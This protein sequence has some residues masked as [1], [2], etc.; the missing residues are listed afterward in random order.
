MI[1][2]GDWCQRGSHF[3]L[4]AFRAGFAFAALDASA[5][6]RINDSTDTRLTYHSTI[7]APPRNSPAALCPP[8]ARG[9][10]RF[11]FAGTAVALFS[12][13]PI[14]PSPKK[15]DMDYH[16]FV[17]A[18]TPTIF[19]AARVA[20]PNL[21]PD[22]GRVLCWEWRH[23]RG[24]SLGDGF[25]TAMLEMAIRDRVAIDG[26]HIYVVRPKNGRAGL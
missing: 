11:Y 19:L 16:E 13:G 18:G 15:T 9:R 7:A 23:V 5:A 20:D 1:R 25:H 12:A 10:G 26:Y 3:A 4:F 22:A 17:C 8:G 6:G 21:I 2:P 24:F 14:R